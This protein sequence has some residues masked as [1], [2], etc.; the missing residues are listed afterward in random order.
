VTATAWSLLSLLLCGLWSLLSP[1]SCLALL[2]KVIAIFAAPFL[3][4]KDVEAGE[5]A[6][7]VGMTDRL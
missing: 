2:G 1:G 5:A 4:W 3:V 7:K 6:A